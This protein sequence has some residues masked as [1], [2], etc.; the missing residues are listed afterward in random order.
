LRRQLDPHSLYNTLNAIAGSVRAAPMTAIH[1]LSSLG[2]LLLLT[3]RDD[4]T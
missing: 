3:L 4:V 1:M 2:D